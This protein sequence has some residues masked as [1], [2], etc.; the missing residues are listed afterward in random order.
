MTVRFLPIVDPR[1]LDSVRELIDLEVVERHL[2]DNIDYRS[3]CCKITEE[4]QRRLYF[5]EAPM[6]LHLAWLDPPERTV[7]YGEEHLYTLA[8]DGSPQLLGTRRMPWLLDSRS[9]FLASDERCWACGERDAILGACVLALDSRAGI[10]YSED[11]ARRFLPSTA[12]TQVTAMERLLRDVCEPSVAQFDQSLGSCNVDS[13]QLSVLRQ[14]GD[15][16]RMLASEIEAIVNPAMRT[17]HGEIFRHKDALLTQKISI[18]DIPS[19][20]TESGRQLVHLAVDLVK[21][22]RANLYRL[23]RTLEHVR[24]SCRGETHA[25]CEADVT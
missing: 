16:A 15:R 22:L 13:L 23:A 6:G 5:C 14:V 24:V 21:P 10:F 12:V 17:V 3:A 25:D 11:E 19:P 4:L 18:S 1:Q 20:L 9:W 2:R 7:R 8:D